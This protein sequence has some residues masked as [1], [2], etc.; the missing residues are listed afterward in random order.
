MNQGSDRVRGLDGLRGIAA[1]AIIVHHSGFWSGATFDGSWG[2]YLG[3]LDIGVPVFFALSGFLL[4]RPIVVAILDD[5]PL[6]PIGEHI[7]RRALRIY[8]AFWVALVLIVAFTTEAFRDT[9]GAVVTALLVHIHWPAHTIG[10]MP[11]AWSLATEVTFYCALPIIARVLRPTLGHLGRAERRNGLYVF[12]LVGALFSIAFRVA[13]LGIDN[14]WTGSAVLWL[15]ATF[16]YFAIGMTLAVAREGHSRDS[17]AGERL[18]RWAG[19]AGWW[20]IAAAALF[21]V[22]S[23]NMGLALGLETASWPREIGRQ[24]VYALIGFCLLYPLVFGGGRRSLVRRAVRSGPMEWF[25]TISYS[26]Y[27]WHMVFIVHP[28]SPLQRAVE[29]V[30][31]QRFLVVLIVAVIPTVVVA[32][33]SYY[34][35]ERTAMRFQP[36]LRRPVVDPTPSESMM[37]RWTRWARGSSYRAQLFVVAGAALLLR[38]GYVLASKRN[39]TLDPGAVFPGDQFY[40]SLAADALADGRGFVVPWHGVS[41]ELGLAEVGSAAPH[42]ADHP[43]LTAIAMAPLSLLPG[44]PGSHVLEQRLAMCLVG[45]LVVVMIGL[46]AR[47]VAGRSAGLVAALIA[48]VYPGFWINDGLVM[49]ESLTTLMVAGA[50]WTAYRYRGSPSLRTAVELGVWIGLA[51]L[52]RSESLLMVPLVAGPVVFVAHVTWRRRVGRSLVVGV[53]CMAAIA[54]WVVPNL[55]RFEEITTMSTNDGL[56]LIGANSPQTFGGD[57]IGFWSLEYA[58]LLDIEQ[59]TGPDPDQSQLSLAYRSEALGYVGDHLNDLP[60]VVVARVGR[61]WSVYRPL[62]MADWNQGEGRELWASHLAMVGIWGLVPLAFIGWWR[63]KAEGRWRW[64]LSAMVVHVTLVAV[65]FYGL[66]RFRVPAEVGL[67]VFAAIGVRWL[68]SLGTCRPKPIS[69]SLPSSS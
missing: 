52:A 20:W 55:F 21:H 67:V 12:T 48:A 33:I 26:V 9:S 63:M 66:P 58:E 69:S 10:P 28:W 53:A 44:E 61:L 2:R 46:L 31:D 49:A 7:W 68:V 6:R 64:P 29:G 47:V 38:F 65:L 23:Q 57:A 39:Q 30:I 11:Q 25:G 3:R 34:V 27:L 17:V 14:R 37:R 36:S 45:A 1:F 54:P 50:L 59:R 19:R 32:T 22:V 18:E 15:P 56:T 42:A 41:I 62:Q 43:P 4:F 13:V 8:P 5:R 24:L 16:D 51:A 40:Y 60:R 35:V